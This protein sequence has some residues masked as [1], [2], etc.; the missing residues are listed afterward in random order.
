M[1]HDDARL[2]DAAATLSAS[3][4]GG[5]WALAGVVSTANAGA[6]M[7]LARKLPLPASGVVDCAG[8]THV[9]SAAVALLLAC[10]RRALAD[11]AKLSFANVPRPL[12]ALATLYGVDEILAL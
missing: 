9:D 6:V 12:A 1:T 2:P 7:E 8:V 5:G 4:D 3:G 10:A 11:G